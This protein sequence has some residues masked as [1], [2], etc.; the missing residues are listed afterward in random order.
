MKSRSGKPSIIKPKVPA[1]IFSEGAA[2]NRLRASRTNL[3]AA[4]SRPVFYALVLGFLTLGVLFVSLPI[5]L[6]ATPPGG[7][8]TDANDETNPLMYTAGPFFISN[9]TAQANGTPICNTA[10]QC[11][12]FL[13]TVSVS[14]GVA[15]TKNVKI[16]VQWPNS[17]ADFDLYVLDSLNNVVTQSASSADPETAFITAVPTTPT[18]YTVRVAPFAP[19]GQSFTG[20]ISLVPKPVS[21]PPGAGLAPRYKDY[22]SP[23]GGGDSAGEPSIGVD[24]NPNVASLKHGTVNTGGVAF[25]TANAAELRT[26][27]DDCSSPAKHTWE[28]V[29]S[30][31]TSAGG[32]DPIGLVDHYGTSP[33]PGRVFQSQLAAAA[34]SILAFSDD[35]GQT[36]TP[37]QGAGQPAGVDHQTIG[38]G[39]Y[40]TMG[41]GGVVPPHPT[42]PNAVYYASQDAATALC[43]RSDNG[44]L[45]FGP[46]VPVYNLT[47]CG[48]IHGHI[49]VAPDGTVYIPNRGCSVGTGAQGVAVS[50]DNGL[51]WTVRTV[52]GSTTSNGD[53]SV[54]IAS[55]GTVYFGFQNGDGHPH[56]AVSQDRGLTWADQDVGGQ[57]NIQNCVFPEVVAGDPQ[58]AAFGFLGT[59]TPG[60]YQDTTNFHGV[61]YFFI[62]TTYD[63]GNTFIT[64]NGT[65]NDPVQVGSICTGGTTCGSDRNLLD[66][67]DITIDKEGRV[68]AAF[69]DGCVAPGCTENSPSAASRS[70]KAT[71]IRQSGG[72]RLLAAF[73]PVEPAAPPAPRLISAAKDSAGVVTVKWDEPDNAGSPLAN[74]KV[75]RGT[76]SGGEALLAMISANSP[77]YIDSSGNPATQYFY[78]VTAVNAQGEGPFCGEVATTAAPPSETPCQ[79]PGRT[80]ADDPAGD[81]TGAPA[82]SELDIT[83]I[84]MAE[85]FLNSCS[86][87]L[88]FTMKVSDLTVV[89]PQARWTIFF[90]RTDN[91]MNSTEY[92]VS[93]SSDSTGNPTGV[94]FDYGHTSIGTGGVRTLTT[95]GPADTGS[96]FSTD[97]TIVILISNS[98]LTFNLNP[99]PATLPP[100]G[101]GEQFTN[102]NA[103]TQ[104]TIGVLLATIDSTG[105]NSYTLVGNLF[106]EPNNP[107]IA[108]LSAT[109]TTGNPPLVVSFDASGSSDPDMCDTVAAYSFNFDDGTGMVVSPSPTIMHTYNSPGQFRATV[110]VIDSRGLISS[111]T[112]S[113]NIEVENCLS[114]SSVSSTG[115]CFTGDAFNGTVDVTAENG[116]GW[117]ATSHDAWITITAGGSG[118]GNGTVS[119]SLAANPTRI[120]R[121]GTM[122]VAGHTFTALQ[123]ITFLDVPTSNVFYTDI[124]KISAKGITVGCDSQNYC[125]GQSVTRAEM[126]AFIVRALGIFDPPPPAS[127][128]FTDVPPSYWAYAFIEELARRGITV[129]CGGGN[130]CPNDPVT[131]EQMAALIMRALGEFNPPPPASQRFN[132]VP[133]SNQFYA[134]IDRLAVLGITLGCQPSPPL[135]CPSD[136]VPREQMAAFLNRAFGCP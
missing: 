21:P 22:A 81:Q 59:T 80:I 136:P 122:T 61:W 105:S 10:T 85:P 42:Y 56:L 102:I 86:N 99:P 131:R 52:P 78:R 54:G 19:L 118:S 24:W 48:G 36:W 31:Q 73:D 71:I 8:L 23:P 1:A 63:G 67:N 4:A 94:T 53:P 127:Q 76:T 38:S 101:P 65:P 41:P 117:T 103:I 133:P 27:F 29:T 51:T 14:A 26:S 109:P 15:A 46:G 112:A 95:D 37:S 18:T 124:G 43:A 9:A 50:T 84:S 64:V 134:F 107:P 119:Y 7:T 113:V 132:D 115:G 72:R 39:P 82:N 114:T 93:M 2:K 5:A 96:T 12:D 28:D 116:C 91:A 68:L 89:P 32:I 92:F 45:T 13:L 90:T 16:Q 40:S 87:Q 135:Y 66:F 129:G 20:R 25:F 121:Q 98:K 47:Q 55:D 33:T 83:K 60:N 3:R 74:Y 125:P 17:A 11:D 97:G 77:K 100:P 111:N 70:A 6:T 35:D 75:Y 128:R 58:R 62:V 108:S 79:L 110:R 57:A 130:F 123:G 30:P 49:R 34:G 88:V 120:P 69:A 104:Q 44:G 126:A 106:C